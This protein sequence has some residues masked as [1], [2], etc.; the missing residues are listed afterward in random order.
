MIIFSD[1]HLREDTESIVFDRVLPGIV[2]A[3]KARDDY[4]IACLGDMLHYRYKVDVRLQ[5]RLGDFFTAQTE[6]GFKFKLLPGNHDQYDT[7]G[8]NALELYGEIPRVMVFTNPAVDPDG[9]WLPYRVDLDVLRRSVT[10]LS[11]LLNPNAKGRRVLFAHHG[12]DGAWMNNHKLNKGG[13]DSNEFLGFDT[14]LLGHYHKRQTIGKASYI[15][16]PY[17][18]TAAE[19][20]QPKGYAHWDGATLTYEDTVWGPRNIN[21]DVADPKTLDLSGISPEDRVRIKTAPGVNTKQVSR[22]LLKSGHLNHVVTPTQ[23]PLQQRLAVESGEDLRVYAEAYVDAQ[24]T[25]L[26]REILMRTYDSIVGGDK[27]A[28]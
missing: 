6:A 25:S 14:V 13:L 19:A 28:L 26:D 4:V 16:S 23:E 17:E 2:E 9:L 15:G 21:L 1:L 12:L 5:N 24:E 3:A 22:A 27:V 18:I 11:Q 8:R 7:A 20:G 10:T